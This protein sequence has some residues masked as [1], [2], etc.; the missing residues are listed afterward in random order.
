MA[1]LDSKFDILRGWPNGSAVSEE[2]KLAA[3]AD[4]NPQ[5]AGKWVPLAAGMAVSDTA[6]TST[7]AV[8]CAL[9]IE[10][11]EDESHKLSGT[12]TVLLGGGYVVRLENKA[13]DGEMFTAA[14]LAPGVPVA[15]AG[16]ILVAAAGENIA[17]DVAVAAEDP[18]AARDEAAP[19]GKVVGF[20][21]DTNLAQGGATGTIDVYIR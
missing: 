15:V 8:G 1:I 20:V 6:A 13:Q 9:V 3:T 7:G 18:V 2:L 14:G 21:L 12:C 5:T 11:R 17:V 16:S 4:T 19:L 10:G